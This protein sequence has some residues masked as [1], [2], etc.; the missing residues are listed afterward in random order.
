LTAVNTESDLIL[1]NDTSTS[2]PARNGLSTPGDLTGSDDVALFVPG[3]EPHSAIMAFSL[4]TGGYS[5]RP[6]DTL[7]FSV[8]QGDSAENVRRNFDCL[9]SRLGLDPRR[10]VTC[11]QVHGDRIAVIEDLPDTP[12]VAD[13]VVTE[14]PNL[15]PAIKTADCL[16]ML[17]IDLRLRVSAAVHCGWRGAV[18]RISRK[19]LALLKDRFRTDPTDLIAVLGPAIGACCYEVDDAVLTPFRQSVPEPERFISHGKTANPGRQSLR[20]DLAGV[21]RAEL[22][23]E[24]VPEENIHQVEGCTCC[25]SSRFFSYRRDGARSGRHI[26]VVGFKN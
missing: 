14:T 8:G 15:Y 9:G 12:P 16:P 10:V 7:N 5:P 25:D 1:G 13:A 19:V 21:N 2:P 26:A 3:L 22:I 6:F 23:S 4:R 18:H 24:G 17:L 11:R 20:L